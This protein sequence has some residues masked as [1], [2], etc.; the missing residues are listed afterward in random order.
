M[1]K[2][3]L[4]G[5]SADPPTIGHQKILSWL[6]QHFDSVAVWASD[7]PFKP[8]QTPL[9]HRQR[10]LQLLIDE[11]SPHRHNIAVCS[12]LSD[13]KTLTSVERAGQ[14]WPQAEFTLVIGSDLLLQLPR[15][16]R[17][18]ELLRQ[19]KLLVVPRRGYALDQA[20]ID[21]L[22]QMGTEVRVAQLSPPAVSSTA[23][24]ENGDTEALTPP[25]EA[26]IHREHLYAC[27][28]AT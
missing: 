5:T 6:S 8:G 10:M 25:V 20:G 26:Y 2:I 7:N 28:D 17:A 19:V 16:Y 15:W 4:F 11:I 18:E 23:Y 27:Q 12:E 3:A 13:R 1:V 14:R 22:R 24:R 9:E 21:Q